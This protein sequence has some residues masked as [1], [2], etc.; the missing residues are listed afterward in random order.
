MVAADQ[1][2]AHPGIAGVS[3]LVAVL[4]AVTAT[5]AGFAFEAGAGDQELGF[6][7]S[8]C[9]ALG[10]IAAV[11]AFRQSGIFTAVTQPPL[12]LFVA[13][14][15]A[16]FM[17]HGSSFA[18]LK[19]VLI[20]CGYP[21]IE[22]FPLML[23][24]SAAVLLIGMARWYFA[25][26]RD[27]SGVVEDAAPTAAQPSRFAGLAARFAALARPTADSEPRHRTSR[28]AAAKPSRTS[29][30]P[31]R[32]RPPRAERPERSASARPRPVRAPRDAEYRDAEYDGPPRP[33]RQPV[34]GAADPRERPRRPR[35]GER[36][37]PPP[38]E[39]IRE[40]REPR[41]RTRDGRYEPQPER[42]YESYRDPYDHPPEPLRRRPAPGNASST[43]HPV[44]RVRYR[45]SADPEDR[46]RR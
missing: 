37:T 31:A 46:Q 30:R 40:G 10:C 33:R 26:G 42:G 41:D 4:I 19:D 9:Y 35:E 28:S 11:I 2:S 22:R 21:L 45:G 6:L 24:T 27:N 12:L 36:R 34:R 20:S 43:H 1:R 38:R 13:V 8:A 32:P 39:R 18:G 15:L 17:F 44:S 3:P 16:Y 5:L 7:F 25:M 14:P 29:A 23:F